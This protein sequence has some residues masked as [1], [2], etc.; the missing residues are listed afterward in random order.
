MF[1]FVIIVIAIVA[2]VVVT[3][4][5]TDVA[6]AVVVAHLL[7]PYGLYVLQWFNTRGMNLRTYVCTYA[8]MNL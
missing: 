6:A 2:A 1:A 3:D 7:L 8:N 4:V 5:A